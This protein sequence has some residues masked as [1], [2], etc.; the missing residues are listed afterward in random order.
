MLFKTN[1]LIEAYLLELHKH[2]IHELS[3]F[4]KTFITFHNIFLNYS[5]TEIRKKYGGVQKIYKRPIRVDR[6]S[7]SKSD[8]HKSR[9]INYRMLIVYRFWAGNS[10][11]FEIVLRAVDNITPLHTIVTRIYVVSSYLCPMFNQIMCKNLCKLIL[12]WS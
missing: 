11:H 6:A 2:L 4:R 12:C 8:R 5:Y 10:I 7:L 1:I 9:Y 3:Q